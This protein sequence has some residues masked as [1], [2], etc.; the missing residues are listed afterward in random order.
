MATLPLVVK[1]H[2]VNAFVLIALLPY[3]RLVHIVTVPLGYLWRLPQLVIWRRS[4]SATGE[5]TR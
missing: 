3:T 4:P 2:A 5:G 1:I